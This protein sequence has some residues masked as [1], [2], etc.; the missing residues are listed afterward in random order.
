V[1][2]KED[3]STLTSVIILASALNCLSNKME[4]PDI[5]IL[6]DLHCLEN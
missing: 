5:V 4:S 1:Y 3:L 6:G 2:R